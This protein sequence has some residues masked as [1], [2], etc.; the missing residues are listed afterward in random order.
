MFIHT[1]FFW[2]KEGVEDKDVGVMEEGLGAL[3]N[4]A[5]VQGGYWGTPANTPRD[6]VDN[7]YAYALT[8]LFHDKNSHDAYQLDDVHVKFV[9]QCSALWLR[10]KVYDYLT[11][12]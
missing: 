5:T 9:E 11:E 3:L 8:V 4:I 10:V 6:V 12:R 1:V 7:S 2:F